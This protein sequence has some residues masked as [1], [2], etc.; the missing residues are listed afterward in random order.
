MD[1]ITKKFLVPTFWEDLNKKMKTHTTGEP[2]PNA[3]YTPTHLIDLLNW[4][5][6][7]RGEP[8]GSQ[9]GMLNQKPNFGMT[10]GSR[11]FVAP[12]Y[13][14]SKSLGG[15]PVYNQHEFKR[16]K[17]LGRWEGIIKNEFKSQGRG[18]IRNILSKNIPSSTSR[19]RNVQTNLKDELLSAITE[20]LFFNR[21]EEITPSIGF[22]GRFGKEKNWG[23]GG[24]I[25]LNKQ[26]QPSNI[27]FNIGRSF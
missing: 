10:K 22:G 27:G 15:A 12:T 19:N 17:D 16:S 24:N 20:K 2:L 9:T 7:S 25:G 26:G 18:I 4:M 8:L 13:T 21:Y 14:K 3:G 5:G 1:K 23:W 11:S 6:D